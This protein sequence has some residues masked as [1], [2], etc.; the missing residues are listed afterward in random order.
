MS[1]RRAL[2]GL[3]TACLIAL[4]A[5]A[6]TVASLLGNFTVNQFAG[7]RVSERALDIRYVVVLGQ[8]PALRE[9]HAAD[10]DRD[11]V[12]TQEE[13]DVF[14]QRLAQEIAGRL[15]VTENGSPVTVRATSWATSLPT[16]QGGF[17]LRLD[18]R[19]VG[20]LTAS[21][22]RRIEFANEN[23]PRQFGWQE[24]VVEPAAHIAVYDADAYSTSLTDGLNESPRELPASGPLAE[25]RVRFTFGTGSVP[26]GSVAIASRLGTAAPTAN[27]ATS[28]DTSG[29]IR[30]Q[31]RRV[32]DLV[33][34]PTVEPGV[35]A[36]A[37]LAAM[38]LGALHAFAPGHGKAVVGAYLVGSRASPRHAAFL[39]LTVTVTHTLG[40]F[41]LGFATLFASAYVV[42]ERIFPILGFVSGLIVL[43]MGIVLAVQRWPAAR[44]AISH[45]RHAFRAAA[46]AARDGFVMGRI[47]HAHAAAGWHSHGGTWHTH[48]PPA[49][50]VTWR[51]LLALGVSG[52]LV[53]CPSA[54][55]LLLAAVGLNKTAFGLVLVLAFSAGLALM[56]TAIGLAFL[57]ARNR[58]P[59][60]ARAPRWT[61]IV[62]LA[63]AG[64]IVLIG[65]LLCH[66][67]LTGGP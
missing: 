42:P 17:S 41:A 6:D 63:S 25:R 24:I 49:D 15:V 20:G 21:G 60:G 12:T 52:G 48:A 18:M 44:E 45:S 5:R 14:A 30:A 23:Y 4:P 43:G 2:A 22:P 9:L 58:L 7:L 65:A 1:T 50:R 46:A 35:A 47:A 28:E 57:Y 66:S 33:A 8:L 56:L 36:L 29:W 31:T 55:V 40:V 61:R 27:D 38:L 32:V 13:R 53:P 59:S 67:A 62:P 64:A 16:E 3:L 34:A 54:M 51:G 37:L 11:G 10:T 19:F 26:A 39:G